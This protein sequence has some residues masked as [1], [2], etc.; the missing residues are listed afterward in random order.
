MNFRK[1]Y[2]GQI[3]SA[4]GGIKINFSLYSDDYKSTVIF[5]HGIETMT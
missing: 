2:I 3:F 4:T 1:I 5:L